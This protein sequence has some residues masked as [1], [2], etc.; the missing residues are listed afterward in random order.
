MNKPNAKEEPCIK[1][2]LE[3][4]GKLQICTVQGK[5][6]VAIGLLDSDCKVIGVMK[7][8]YQP[9]PF[10]LLLDLKCLSLAVRYPW[11]FST[12]SATCLAIHH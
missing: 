12:V 5:T 10:C 11:S 1:A 8:P 9:N 6:D 4:N 2:S 7:V 3:S